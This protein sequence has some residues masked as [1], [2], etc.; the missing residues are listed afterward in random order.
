MAISIIFKRWAISVASRKSRIGLISGNQATTSYCLANGC[1][2]RQAS[3]F[4][5]SPT[6][7]GRLKKR[8]RLQ[9]SSQ[10]ATTRPGGESMP[11]NGAWRAAIAL[12]GRNGWMLNAERCW[13]SRAF[14][15]T[16]WIAACSDSFV[17][18]KPNLESRKSKVINL[19]T[20]IRNG[21]QESN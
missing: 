5:L 19:P 10:L 7:S 13:L 16:R 4:T 18:R 17:E 11:L 21:R 20:S 14:G 6:E 1:Q 9:S 3:L 2:N 12:L 15:T 8:N